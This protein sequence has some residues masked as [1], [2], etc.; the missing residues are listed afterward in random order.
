MTTV[1]TR[2]AAPREPATKLPLTLTLLLETFSTVPTQRV[3]GPSVC[4]TLELYESL[5][6]FTVLF[7]S[8]PAMNLNLHNSNRVVSLESLF[9]NLQ[10]TQMLLYC[11]FCNRVR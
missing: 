1:V 6:K 7:I 2:S 10:E 4:F 9:I 8:L 3:P 5:V 11:H